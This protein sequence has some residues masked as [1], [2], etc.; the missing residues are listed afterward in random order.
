MMTVRDLWEA[1]RSTGHVPEEFDA[2]GDAVTTEADRPVVVHDGTPAVGDLL[3]VKSL[4]PPLV[5][6]R[7]DDPAGGGASV[8][9]DQLLPFRS[10]SAYWHPPQRANVGGVVSTGQPLFLDY[11]WL[12]GYYAPVPCRLLAVGLNVTT[13][14]AETNSYRLAIYDEAGGEPNTLLGQQQIATDTAGYKTWTLGTPLT[15]E[16][17]FYVGG[18]SQ[19][20]GTMPH[21]RLLVPREFLPKHNTAEYTVENIAMSLWRTGP[22]STALAG[23]ESYFLHGN[24]TQWIEVKLEV[25]V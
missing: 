3:R 14:G 5:M 21:T 18:G 1:G 22:I 7:T 2:W 17:W 4:G 10:G 9:K 15:V 16:G 8:T 23:T 24:S 11:L 25:I 19:G 20:T 13:P 6:E 12:N